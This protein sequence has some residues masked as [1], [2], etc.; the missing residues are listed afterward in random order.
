MSLSGQTVLI[1]GGTGSWGRCAVRRWLAMPDGPARLI[2][3][4]DSEASHA[5]MR[6]AD[7]CYTDPR[8]EY[9][10][11][12]VRDLRRLEWA[13]QPAS[14]V[15]H[16]AAMKEIATCHYNPFE[17]LDTNIIGSANVVKAAVTCGV[18]RALLLSTDKA[19][20]PYTF[21][22]VTKAAAEALFTRGNT[23]SGQAETRFASV[24]YGNIRG[25]RA[26]VIP[27][28]QACVERGEPIPITDARMTRYWWQL[29]DAVRLVEW[30]LETMQGGEVF[31]PKL[32]ASPI[33]ALAD[34]IVPPGWPRRETGMTAPEKLHEYLVSQDEA[35]H[36]VELEDAYVIL[37]VDPSW[38]FTPPAG[39]RPVGEHF[40][41]SSKGVA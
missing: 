15:I 31:V 4:A 16:A 12:N 3:F 39:A 36:T 33:A 8:L 35:L 34:D 14:V 27:R 29:E 40:S 21:Y 28:W 1:T 32:A 17:A 24:R 25:S 23:L 37:P 26:S 20:A 41:Y 11:G 7:P 18:K 13:F 30:A 5:A 10:V 2:V 9:F 6:A 22:G 38:P 19:C